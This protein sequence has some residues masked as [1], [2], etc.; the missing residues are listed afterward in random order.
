MVEA[1]GRLTAL[2]LKKGIDSGFPRWT[3]PSLEKLEL[4]MT[5]ERR[6]SRRVKITAASTGTGSGGSKK[7]SRG[8]AKV[9]NYQTGEKKYRMSR[10][11]LPPITMQQ[12]R[13]ITA[14]WLFHISEWVRVTET[15]RDGVQGQM[16]PVHADLTYINQRSRCWKTFAW[17]YPANSILSTVCS[18]NGHRS[19]RTKLAFLCQRDRRRGTSCCCAAAR[20]QASPSRPA[21]SGRPPARSQSAGMCP[22]PGPAALNHPDSDILSPS[23]SERPLWGG[24]RGG[25]ERYLWAECSRT[26]P[27]GCDSADILSAG[28]WDGAM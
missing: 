5:D 23:P 20:L 13:L 2:K 1:V 24:V 8:H 14:P 4:L 22:G 9:C 15:E 7:L 18:V 28:R 21:L 3:L 26:R 11:L 12:V 27:C 10:L 25:W 19:A 17:K 6:E 16:R